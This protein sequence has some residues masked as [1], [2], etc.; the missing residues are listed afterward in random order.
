MYGNAWKSMEKT[1]N[2]HG[3]DMGKYGQVWKSVEEY[4]QV[5]R[6]VETYGKVLKSMQT[7]M[8]KSEA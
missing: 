7:S 8:E 3:E 2:R 6:S 1:R 4:G 5:W